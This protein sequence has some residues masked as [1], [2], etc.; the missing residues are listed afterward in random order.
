MSGDKEKPPAPRWIETEALI[1]NVSGPVGALHPQPWMTKPETKRVIAALTAGGDEVRFIGGCVRDALIKRPV[2]DIDIALSAPP[3]RVCQLLTAAGVRVVPTGIAHG[4]VTAVIGHVHFE[5]TSLRVDVETFGR[6]ARVEFTDDWSQDAARRDFTINAMSCTPD[7]TIYDYF[8]GLD[9][10]AVG[11][12]RFVGDAT[13]RIEEDALRLLR[14]FRFYAV[15]G[16]PPAD[17]H[18]LAACRA[19]AAD[20]ARLSVERV[21]GELLRLLMAPEPADVLQLMRDNGVLAHVLPEAG[22]LERLKRLCWLESHALARPSVK[23]D[24]TRRLAALFDADGGIALRLANRLKFSLRER[25]RLVTAAAR[26]WPGALADD[27]RA[28]AKALHHEGVHAVRDVALIEWADELIGQAKLP[29][30]RTEAWC[31]VLDTIDS[32][33]EVTFP[34]KGRDAIALGVPHGR[35]I[36]RLLRE[37]EDWWEEGGYVAGRADCLEKLKAVLGEEG[38]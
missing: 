5:I 22:R 6:H 1:L 9:D 36:G 27:P 4:T 35:S 7:G 8:G 2:Q 25:K 16:E 28:L 12:V 10:L 38:R 33:R 26:P 30:A 31:R 17:E 37:V 32:W 21:R 11:R 34:L 3:D 24:P 20:V 19:R 14:F 29:R 23:P 18:A 15:Y 13:Q